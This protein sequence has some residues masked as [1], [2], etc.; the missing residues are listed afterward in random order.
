MSGQQFPRGADPDAAHV[1]GS[2]SA[3]QGLK[4]DGATGLFVPADFLTS[5]DLTGLAT[6]T[7]VSDAI[8]ALVAGAPGALDTLLEIAD[9]LADDESAVAALT[10]TVAGKLAK[11]SNLSDL[12]DASTARTNLGLGALAVL[13]TING[14]NWSGTDLAVVDGGTGASSASVARTNLGAESSTVEAVNAASFATGWSSFGAPYSNLGYY[15]DRDRIYIRGAVKNGG[16]GTGDIFTL[17]AGYR[18]PANTQMFVPIFG[19]S[20]LVTVTSAGVVTDQTFSA[21]SKI[22]TVLDVVNFRAA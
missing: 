15:R 20:G 4:Y 16:T 6:T 21:N 9:Q 5:S 13:A 8:D 10:T 17:P 7:D 19:G 18:P 12:T 22:V 14:S 11:A 3:D 2:F 1:S